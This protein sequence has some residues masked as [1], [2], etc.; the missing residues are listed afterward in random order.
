MNEDKKRK[1]G[2]NNLFFQST[3]QEEKNQPGGMEDIRVSLLI[4]SVRQL[5]LFISFFLFFFLFFF[6]SFC[7]SLLPHQLCDVY[8]FNV[9]TNYFNFKA[10]NSQLN[11]FQ[12]IN[13]LM[14]QKKIFQP[15]LSRR[16]I[17]F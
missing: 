11:L 12:I 17:S 13:N 2:Y 3:L 16:F 15:F 4:V 7:S 14:Y 9:P 1:S 5:K 10:E 6:N 8:D